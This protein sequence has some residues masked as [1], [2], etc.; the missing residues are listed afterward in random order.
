MHRLTAKFIRYALTAVMVG[1]F[2]APAVAQVAASD[3]KAFGYSDRYGTVTPTQVYSLL[4]DFEAVFMYY[5][6]NHQKAIT[7]RVKALDL[8]PVT[9]KT[10]EHAFVKLHRLSDSIDKLANRIRLEPMKRILRENKKAIPAE[11]FLQTGNNLDAMVKI[12]TKLEA[13][14]AWGDYYD[15]RQDLKNKKP[16]DV[17]AL[18]DLSIRRLDVVLR[19]GNT[20]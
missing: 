9:G 4:K 16:N 13:N 18:A 14:K 17:F 15:L 12:M 10:P 1:S 7:A 11:V 5:V 3:K 19:S 2:A 6:D 20:H 8:K